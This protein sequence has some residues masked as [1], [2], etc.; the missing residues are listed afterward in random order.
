ML[1]ADDASSLRSMMGT[2]YFMSFGERLNLTLNQLT[3]SLD[4]LSKK[5]PP[6]FQD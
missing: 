4:I 3:E 6:N 1:A 5:F 2:K